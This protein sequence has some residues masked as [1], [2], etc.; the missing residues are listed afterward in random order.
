MRHSSQESIE[1]R[2]GWP[3]GPSGPYLRAMCP[4]VEA[5]GRRLAAWHAGHLRGCAARDSTASLRSALLHDGVDDTLG[6]VH[7][8]LAELR[9]APVELAARDALVAIP[10][11]EQVGHARVVGML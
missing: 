2:T 4:W 11:S 6:D 1:R 10:D 3:A 5:H 8:G 9:E 7:D